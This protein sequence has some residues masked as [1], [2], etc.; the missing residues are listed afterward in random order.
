MVPYDLHPKM[1]RGVKKQEFFL[2]VVFVR[3]V[4]T[5][6]TAHRDK[7]CYHIFRNGIRIVSRTSAFLANRH[8]SPSIFGR[9]EISR[10]QTPGENYVGGL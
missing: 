3:K 2:F 7:T 10:N 4:G 6:E 9:E 5:S 8:I 1:G